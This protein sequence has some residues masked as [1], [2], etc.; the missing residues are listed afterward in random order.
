M[1]KEIVAKGNKNVQDNYTRQVKESEAMA[2]RREE[3]ITD[4][5]A[6]SDP[7]NKKK[8]SG[9]QEFGIGGIKSM[10]KGLAHGFLK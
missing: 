10:F 3:V 5:Q 4:M 9:N 8:H 6:Q 2:K 7:S 1:E